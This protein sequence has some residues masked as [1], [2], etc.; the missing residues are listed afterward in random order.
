MDG[1]DRLYSK[2]WGVFTH[3]LYGTPNAPEQI[4]GEQDWNQRV[5]SVNVEK[6]ARD[7]HDAGAGYHFMTIMQGRK[8]MLGPNATFDRIAGTVPG[9]ACSNRDLVL[10]LAHA[11]KKYDIDLYLYFTGDG[12]YKDVEV[13]KKFGFWEPRGYVTR[14]FVEK[15][16]S[17]LGE[18]ALR[19]GD[20]VKGWW[21][22]GCYGNEF[23]YDDSLLQLYYDAVKRGNPNAL[24]AFNNGVKRKLEKWFRDEDFT[25]GEQTDFIGIPEKRFIDGAQA[26]ILAPMGI[27]SQENPLDCWCRTGCRRDI[28]YMIDYV[29]KVNQAGGVVTIDIK[30][31]SDGSFDPE[32]LAFL[33]KMGKAL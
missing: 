8:Y 20:L 23:H 7:L 12:P 18:Y 5:E 25:S 17:V 1:K 26:H 33:R 3:Y 2:K 19:Y 28:D 21:I 22:D 9:E 4:S 14:E 13:G 10:E 24:V 29:R 32:Q 15:W 11:L 6:I 27:P 31:W 16:A 30:I